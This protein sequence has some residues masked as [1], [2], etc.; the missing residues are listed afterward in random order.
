MTLCNRHSSVRARLLFTIDPIPLESPRGYL[1]RVAHAHWY[2]RPSWLTDLAG[3]PPYGLEL[4]HRAKRLAFVLRLETTEWMQMC[5][6]RIKG[7]GR[8]FRRSFLN[9]EIDI[10]QLNYRYPRICPCCL[11]KQ[12]VWWAVWDLALVAVCPIHRCFLIDQCSSCEKRL[13][14][15]RP[16]VHECRCGADLRTAKH[17]T[18]DGLLI[19]INAAIYQAAGFQVLPGRVAKE[20]L[21]LSLHGVETRFNIARNSFSGIDPRSRKAAPQTTEISINRLS[22]RGPGRE[23]SRRCIEGLAAIFLPAAET[24]SLWRN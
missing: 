3:I 7:E 23:C 8:F 16:A 19:A 6:I 9:R 1:C 5:Y 24:R 20:Q 11:S 10:F 21:S 13:K 2:D 22:R 18:A 4:E 15:N 14:W 12:S 17:Q